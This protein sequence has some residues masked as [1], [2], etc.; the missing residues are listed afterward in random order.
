MLR[1]LRGPLFHGDTPRRRQH[2]WTNSM[3]CVAPSFSYRLDAP[4][5]QAFLEEWLD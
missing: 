2:T 5:A 4:L 1:R 3:R